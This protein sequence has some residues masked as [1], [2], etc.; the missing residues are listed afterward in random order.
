MS[1]SLGEAGVIAGGFHHAYGGGADAC[2]GYLNDGP[3]IG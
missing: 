2:A 1:T 3:D